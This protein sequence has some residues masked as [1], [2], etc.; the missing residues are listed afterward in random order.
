ME[1]EEFHDFVKD[2]KIETPLV[3][4]TTL[5]N[6]F[7]KANATNTQEAFLQRK[8]ER[9]NAAVQKHLE[10]KG[11]G[12]D[13]YRLSPKH[14]AFPDVLPDRFAS[15]YPEHGSLKKAKPDNRLVLYEF[16]AC[17]VRIAFTRSALC[18]AL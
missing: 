18:S 11:H 6:I 12:R 10:S 1:L 5:S 8:A 16:L 3:T 17:L 4:F 9:R 15:E 7:A 14:G 13:R 2:A